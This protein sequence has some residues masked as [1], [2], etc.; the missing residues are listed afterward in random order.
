MVDNF[1]FRQ[2]TSYKNFQYKRKKRTSKNDPSR[3]D[4]AIAIANYILK[5][6]EIQVLDYSGDTPD[7]INENETENDKIKE[8]IGEVL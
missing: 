3:D 8:Q 4:V 2:K 7:P 5:G 1:K 6:G